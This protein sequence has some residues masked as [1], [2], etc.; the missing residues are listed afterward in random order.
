MSLEPTSPPFRELGH[1][2]ML[3]LKQHLVTELSREATPAASHRWLPRSRLAIVAVVAALLLMGTAIAATADWLSGD[4]A[5]HAVVT[6]FGSY[7]PQL[8][9]DPEPGRAVLVAEDGDITLYATN[10]KQGGYC[11]IASAPWKRPSSLSD[12]GTCVPR[13]FVAAPLVE[14][15][16]HVIGPVL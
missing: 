1:D 9:F 7:A 16:H 15:G 13:T 6:D 10:N 12:G 11:L 5:P 2:R 8:G 4:P 3:A 14:L